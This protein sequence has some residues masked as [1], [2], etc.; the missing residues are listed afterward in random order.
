M[1]LKL[2]IKN[3]Y[4]T[5]AFIII[6]ILPY[7]LLCLTMGGFHG[8]FITSETCTHKQLP[9][10]ITDDH[11]INTFEP[12]HQHNFDTCHICQWLKSPTISACILLPYTTFDFICK[13]Y[14]CYLNPLLPLKPVR[15][16]TIR[17]PPLSLSGIITTQ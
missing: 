6:A 16:F 15:K 13:S 9:L 3:R 5:K 7:F 1:P 11:Y 2:W 8:S 12:V 14:F 4:I 17:S 10:N